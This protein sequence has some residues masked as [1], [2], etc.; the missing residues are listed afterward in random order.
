MRT[1]CDRP[2]PAIGKSPLLN[3]CCP[4]GTGL[5]TRVAS[6]IAILCLSKKFWI[7]LCWNIFFTIPGQLWGRRVHNAYSGLLRVLLICAARVR[8]GEVGLSLP[9]GHAVL[10]K[11]VFQR[12]LKVSQKS[13]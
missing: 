10:S 3:S 1:A 12:A 4:G 8:R 13:L 7:Q 6:G 5:I 2:V 9:A 11:N